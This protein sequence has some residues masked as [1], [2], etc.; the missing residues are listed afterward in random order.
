MS[1]PLSHPRRIVV[2][3]QPKLPETDAEA[4]KVAD[5]LREA[6]VK[7]VVCTSLYDMTL[8]DRIEGGEFDLLV[9]LGGDGSML[10]AGQLSARAGI[11]VLGIN[12]GHFGFLTEI[13]REQWPALLPKLLRGE[14]RIE[15]RIML[16]TRHMRNGEALGEWTA[17]NECVVCRGQFVRPI[18]LKAF[19]DDYLLTSYIADGLIISTPTGSTAYALAAGGP[20]MPPETDN[21]LIIPLAP[22]LSMDRAIILSAETRVRV[23]AYTSHEAVLSVDGRPSIVVNDGDEILLT[24]DDHRARFVRL[25]DPGYFYRNISTYMEQNPSIGQAE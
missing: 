9:A 20:I 24:V 14:Y 1:D 22:H 17:L 5:F 2:A 23:E 6:G 19:A 3:S 12:L 25:Q 15:E 10:R 7:T 18:H 11:P 4:H 21:I 16:K 8:K 13:R